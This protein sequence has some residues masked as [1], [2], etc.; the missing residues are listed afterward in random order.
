MERRYEVQGVGHRVD[1][2]EGDGVTVMVDDD[3]TV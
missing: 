1:H 2:G 3:V